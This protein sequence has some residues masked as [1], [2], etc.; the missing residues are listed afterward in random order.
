MG[1][2]VQSR[3]KDR[4]DGRQVAKPI[5]TRRPVMEAGITAD[6]KSGRQGIEGK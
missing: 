4:K 3:Q 5:E 1:R 6:R 2:K